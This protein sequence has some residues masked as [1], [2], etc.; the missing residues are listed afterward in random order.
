[1]ASATY[2]GEVLGDG[3]LSLP[4]MTREKLQLKSGEKVEVVLH[5]VREEESLSEEAYAPLRQLVGLVKEGR[6][7]GS[8]NH[9][10]YLY[11]KDRP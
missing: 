8:V 11:R 3:H 9:D 10:E 4:Q 5:T 6:S 1:M 7:D 2:I